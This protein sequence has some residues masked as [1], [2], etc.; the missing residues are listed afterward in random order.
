MLSVGALTWEKDPLALL[1]VAGRVLTKRT[2]AFHLLVGD[3]PIRPRLEAAV[4]SEGLSER[5]RLLGRS[6]DVTDLVHASD[7]L[8]LASKV[9]GLPGIAIEAGTG[10]LPVVAYAVGGLPEIV[11]EGVT[12][13]LAP[14]GNV[15]RLAAH[16]L[17]LMVDPGMRRRM[18]QAASR[19]VRARYDIRSVAP[20]YLALYREVS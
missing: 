10:G 14:P 19:R 3:G 9:E 12:G 2:D 1:E 6:N 15:D 13:L 20:R 4:R 16:M 17:T 7:A 8:L 5:V 18:G 11:E